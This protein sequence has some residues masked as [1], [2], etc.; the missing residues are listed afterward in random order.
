M[1]LHNSLATIIIAV[2]NGE[3]T[4]V[5]CLESIRIQ[6]YKS[7]EVIVVD[8]GSTDG[9]MRIVKEYES[10]IA[11]WISEPD[12]GVYDAWNKALDRAQGKWILFL[13]CDDWFAYPQALA[14][15]IRLAEQQPDVQFVSAQAQMFDCIGNLISIRGKE[16]QWKK[17]KRKMGV[18]VHPGALHSRQLFEQ[19]G[20]FNPTIRIVGDYDF[21]L[22]PGPNL[23][24]AYLPE[25]AVCRLQNGITHRN[26]IRTYYDA[27]LVQQ[28]SGYISKRE[29]ALNLVIN[30]CEY[31]TG[32]SKFWTKKTLRRLLYR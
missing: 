23:R 10:D 3:D 13:G 6:T 21:L 7:K 29:A 26:A 17:F 2:F 5:Q 31:Y 15:L 18:I 8:G 27:Y 16:W 20:R 22:R 32:R 9:S 14:R 11:Y 24:T 1:G 25:V 12:K 28:Q 19:Y 4:L 30:L